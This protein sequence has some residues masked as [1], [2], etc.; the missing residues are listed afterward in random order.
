MTTP[1][2]SL[3]GALSDAVVQL[4]VAP[5]GV[6]V[7]IGDVVI[8]DAASD[9]EVHAGDLVLGVGLTP[10]D[11]A[12]IGAMDRL[13]AVGAAGLVLRS[14]GSLP[15]AT[16]RHAE[17]SGL[18]LLRAGAHVG[19]GRIYSLVRTA[20]AAHVIESH[21]VPRRSGADGGPALG[22]LFALANAI[23][24]AVGGA[25]TIEDRH[26][27]VLAHSNLGHPVD[28]VRLDSIVGRR[29][30]DQVR[31]DTH[32]LYRRVWRASGVYRVRAHAPSGS[33]PRLG[34]AVRAGAE[35][36]GTIWVIEGDTT[37]TPADHRALE[38]AA[39]VAALHLLRHAAAGDVER[40]RRAELAASVLEGRVPFA[41]AADALGME[42]AAMVT[43]IAFDATGL[44]DDV[45]E[46]QVTERLADLVAL[47][48]E[49]FRRSAAIATLGRVVY[50]L[51]AEPDLSTS[52][53]RRAVVDEAVDR[54]RHSLQRRVVAGIGSTVSDPRAVVSSR[55]DADAVLAVLRRRA[56]RAVAH[57]DDVRT[58]VV[59]DRLRA[60][61]AADDRLHAGLLERLRAHDDRHH[62]DYVVSVAAY[63]GSF[64][65]VAEAAERLVL[66]PNTLRYRLR[67][68]AEST[69]VDLA[70]PETRFVLELELRTA[71]LMSNPE[72]SRE[73]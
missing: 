1:L 45:R 62:S 68:I 3:L 41:R 70:D 47:H 54:A 51:V 23:A 40:R 18:T 71:G 72:T 55:E 67:R 5:L 35:V 13:V 52:P 69:G 44:D 33:R 17:R 58:S 64:G 56:D 37:F 24:A 30:P 49:S 25:T 34:V 50:A 12:T 6:D 9:G 14:T 63:L 36:L 10:D 57:I 65:A 31:A 66:H 20:L 29:V 60:V 59:L 22:D 27:H 16:R 42:G 43:V 32:E 61:V 8:V 15:V 19:W 28:Q 11:P 7:S 38:E 26:L 73:E 4:E 48:L 2:E 46:L 39:Q 53:R 21:G